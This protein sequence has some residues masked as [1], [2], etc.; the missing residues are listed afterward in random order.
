MLQVT[1]P[2]GSVG[3]CRDRELAKRVQ[4]QLEYTTLR[5]VTQATEIHYDPDPRVSSL[6]L[7]QGWTLTGVPWHVGGRTA[8]CKTFVRAELIRAV[9]I[10][11]L[12][13]VRIVPGSLA[14]LLTGQRVCRRLCHGP[15]CNFLLLA[16]QRFLSCLQSTYIEEDKSWVGDY[17]DMADAG[18]EGMLDRMSPWLLRIGEGCTL[19]LMPSPVPGYGAVPRE[20]SRAA[21]VCD[22]RHSCA[23]RRCR[24]CAGRQHR[25]Q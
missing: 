6:E 11:M 7:K 12:S 5:R 1:N 3:F 17:F 10:C 13:I 4:C 20:H 21:P 8:L 18:E 15:A 16:L 19:S 24:S 9:P 25:D 23:G 2:D 14:R 22:A